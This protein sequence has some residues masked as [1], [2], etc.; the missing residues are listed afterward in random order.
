[1]ALPRQHD[2]AAT[3]GVMDRKAGRFTI[4]LNKLPKIQYLSDA[5]T[6]GVNHIYLCVVGNAGAGINNSVM[7]M[8]TQ[9][10]YQE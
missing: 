9:L 2:G 7:Y 4:Y 5:G 8:T 1:M 3:L 6:A 10:F